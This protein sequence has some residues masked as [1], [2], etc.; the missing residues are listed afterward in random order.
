MVGYGISYSIHFSATTLSL[1]MCLHLWPSGSIFKWVGQ[2]TWVIMG[3]DVKIQGRNILSSFSGKQWS[4]DNME[5][6]IVHILIHC[7]GMFPSW[8]AVGQGYWHWSLLKQ[9]FF[10]THP[11]L[12]ALQS[13]LLMKV[14][15]FY[16]IS[17][18]VSLNVKD[19]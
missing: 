3:V 8:E 10:F 6:D 15:R 4:Y 11:I 2:F 1:L 9:S 17:G 7:N 18:S 19:M 5:L 13:P 12:M 14:I 16:F